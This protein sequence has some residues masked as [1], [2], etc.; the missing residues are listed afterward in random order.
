[1]SNNPKRR[2]KLKTITEIRRRNAEFADTQGVS[3]DSTGFVVIATPASHMTARQA[4][5]HASH[6]IAVADPNPESQEFVEILGK[7]MQVYH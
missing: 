1:M 3:L 2:K 4:L 7:V 6:L 5:I